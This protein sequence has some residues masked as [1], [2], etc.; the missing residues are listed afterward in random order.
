MKFPK[1]IGGD[2]KKS[3]FRAEEAEKKTSKETTTPEIR[4][5]NTTRRI[6]H[7]PEARNIFFDVIRMNFPRTSF[8][9]TR[10]SRQTPLTNFTIH[11][12]KQ[13]EEHKAQQKQTDDI[14]MGKYTIIGREN[15]L[16]HVVRAVMLGE[17]EKR[18][19]RAG[20][21]VDSIHHHHR[22]WFWVSGRKTSIKFMREINPTPE[23]SEQPKWDSFSSSSHIFAFHF[24]SSFAINP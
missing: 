23:P 24:T 13:F 21:I 6:T 16:C 9:K 14:A 8:I 3:I 15:Y 11:K 4:G 12:T 1:N 20:R 17:C 19:R 5:I 22:A 18:A 7:Q 2:R 10:N